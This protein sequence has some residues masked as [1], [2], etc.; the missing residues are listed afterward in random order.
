LHQEELTT[1]YKLHNM[2]KNDKECIDKILPFLTLVVVT[3]KER[4]GISL[5]TPKKKTLRRNKHQS[6][7]RENGYGE[8]NMKKILS[9]PR[10]MRT[11]HPIDYQERV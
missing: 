2:T 10:R 3:E 1:I 4:R 5:T 8:I 11:I 6:V 9:K 7:K